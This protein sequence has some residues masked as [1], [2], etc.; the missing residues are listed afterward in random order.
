MVVNAF[1]PHSFKSK[2]RR[3]IGSIRQW[4]KGEQMN[5]RTPAPMAKD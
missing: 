3:L 5:A 4:P 1:L 2:I